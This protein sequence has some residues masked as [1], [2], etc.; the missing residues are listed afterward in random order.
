VKKGISIVEKLFLEDGAIALNAFLQNG[1][2]AM[3]LYQ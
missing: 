3:R 1:E 2:I